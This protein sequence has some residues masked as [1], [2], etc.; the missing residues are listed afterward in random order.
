MNG[1]FKAIKKHSDAKT[2]RHKGALKLGLRLCAS[3][4]LCL[5]VFPYSFGIRLFLSTILRIVRI[6]SAEEEPLTVL[7]RDV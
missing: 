4:S 3:V 7:E 5:C 1:E 2:Q 6:G